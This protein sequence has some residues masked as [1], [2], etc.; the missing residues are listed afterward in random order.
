MCPP[1]AT[2]A[3]FSRSAIKIKHLYAHRLELNTDVGLWRFVLRNRERETVL[4]WHPLPELAY[5]C[6]GSDIDAHFIIELWQQTHPLFH[7][8]VI[9]G[10]AWA[11]A[12]IDVLLWN[13]NLVTWRCYFV[14][15][16][17][18]GERIASTL[19]PLAGEW[20]PTTSSGVSTLVDAKGF[21]RPLT[22]TSNKL[23]DG[24]VNSREHIIYYDED[25]DE[26]FMDA[27]LCN[28]FEPLK[29]P[30][31]RE[32]YSNRFVNELD[33]YFAASSANNSFLFAFVWRIE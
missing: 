18:N 27:F 15:E 28:I 11:T 1:P 22:G 31:I 9:A 8:M 30:N 5:V 10:D 13:C 7:A 19:W 32:A 24:L 16:C 20:A 6:W 23:N 25:V 21:A 3:P 26:V 33:F 2:R 12:W 17:R 4:K 14:I 29:L